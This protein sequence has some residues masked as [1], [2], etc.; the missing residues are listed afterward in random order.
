MQIDIDQILPLC[1]V[2]PFA[3]GTGCGLGV[4]AF[5]WICWIAGIDLE[6]K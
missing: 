3:L 5:V 2:V 4:V 6:N 1:L